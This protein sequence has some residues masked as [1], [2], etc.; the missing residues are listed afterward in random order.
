MMEKLR[1]S[2]LDLAAIIKSMDLSC[3]RQVDFIENIW[4]KEHRY[5]K[6][7]YHTDKRSLILDTQYWLTYLSDKFTFDAEFP[8]IQRDVKAFG[9]ELI[10]E[11]YIADNSGF[12]LF[13]K[14]TRFRILYG[15]GNDFVKVKR[16]TLMKKYRYKRL[17]SKLASYFN[18][19]IDFYDLQTYVRGR[20][21][22]RIEDTAINDT[23]VFRV[24]K[25]P[26]LQ[27]Y[28]VHFRRK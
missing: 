12:D 25:E 15:G 23:L 13:F 24:K 4:A 5:L 18:R 17:S 3:Q 16:R 9:G 8:V 20:I 22:C 11:N 14:S 28:C 10:K 6:Q 7:E 21:K 27:M 2:A 1:C 19:C 26:N